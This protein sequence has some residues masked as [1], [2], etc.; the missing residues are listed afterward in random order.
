[1][2]SLNG[3]FVF[4]LINFY[5]PG[6]VNKVSLSGDAGEEGAAGPVSNCH[7]DIQIHR[8]IQNWN[9]W[10]FYKFPLSNED[11]MI[12]GAQNKVLLKRRKKQAEKLKSREMK[13]EWMKND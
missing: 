13:E 9:S 6:Q 5:S 4:Q 12:Q 11:R 2:K 3:T 7:Q 10:I 8:W 1:M